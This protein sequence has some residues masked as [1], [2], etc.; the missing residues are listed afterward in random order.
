MDATFSVQPMIKKFW[1]R[2]EWCYMSGIPALRRQIQKDQKN[3]A[4]LG[5]K[6]DPV[7][8]NKIGK[9]LHL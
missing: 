7:S 3:K 9:K 2:L 1:E 4:S 8:K 5:Y 6:Q